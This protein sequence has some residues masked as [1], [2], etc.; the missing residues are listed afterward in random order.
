MVSTEHGNLAATCALRRLRLSRSFVH[1]Q[2]EDE[3]LG[4][5]LSER[6]QGVLG[7]NLQGMRQ[8]VVRLGTLEVHP[9]FDALIE[10]PEE[11]EGDARD[12]QLADYV[13][14]DE[15]VKDLF[16]DVERREVLYLK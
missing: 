2:R 5:A 3:V 7:P 11:F 13:P 8:L 6:P 4:R 1:Y 16:C 9:D 10:L 12:F 15:R 14:C